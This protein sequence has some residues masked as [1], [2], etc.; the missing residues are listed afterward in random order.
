M[1]DRKKTLF[2]EIFFIVIFFF[3]CLWS[4]WIN[5][6]P[7]GYVIAQGDEP[8]RMNLVEDYKNY[9]YLWG[10][11]CGGGN[12]RESE[13]APLPQNGLY[14]L[15][16]KL[17]F[18]DTSRQNLKYFFFFFGSGLSAFF[19]CRLFLGSESK[20]HIQFLSALFY[21]FNSFT[22][23]A[24]VRMGVYYPYFDSY[25]FLPLTWAIFVRGLID[26]KGHYLA[27]FVLLVFI[28]G[29]GLGHA[30]FLVLFFSFMAATVIFLWGKKMIGRRQV[31]LA[32]VTLFFSVLSLSYYVLHYGVNLFF[33]EKGAVENM[34]A[35]KSL[36]QRILDMSPSLSNPLR[37]HIGGPGFPDIFPYKSLPK[38]PFLALAYYPVVLIVLAQIKVQSKKLRPWLF[39]AGVVY[40]ISLFGT[41]KT[42]VA[43]TLS[44]K[45]FSL[46]I[47][48]FFRSNE[49]FILLIPWAVLLYLIIFV[50]EILEKTSS[51]IKQYGLYLSITII[52]FLVSLPLFV[53]RLNDNFSIAY[54]WDYKYDVKVK[55]PEYYKE[56]AD[57]VNNDKDYYKALF[58]P[59]GGQTGTGWSLFPKWKYH[60]INPFFQYF[61]N[62][63]Y[64]PINGSC[65]FK[66]VVYLH[67]EPEK[68]EKLYIPLLQSKG[69]RY[70]VINNDSDEE[71]LKT[72][73]NF[74][75]KVAANFIFIKSF[76][77]LD[78]FRILPEKELP[79][80][81]ALSEEE[82]PSLVRVQG[83]QQ[84]FRGYYDWDEA[85]IRVRDVL[86]RRENAP[87]LSFTKISPVKYQVEIKG[88]KTP[89]W[90][91]FS[92][93]FSK[94]WKIYPNFGKKSLGDISFL[95]TEPL[96]SQ[97]IM[98]NDFANSW[99]INPEKEKTGENFS[100][101]IFFLPQV[102]FIFGL[103]ISII[104]VSVVV[105]YLL[106]FVGCNIY[107]KYGQT[108]H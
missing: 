58:M 77:N 43:G 20:P 92:D 93:T 60:G 48:S 16:A 90:L 18:S 95:F 13:L 10:Y 36:E 69:I 14:F 82:N 51:K 2:K 27:L 35:G 29:N 28:S 33:S 66:E 80:L 19:A 12:Y 71:Y 3:I 100:L 79:V 78:L 37:L 55:I 42:T 46:L 88:A 32:L 54:Q 70:L 49:K 89:F 4:W 85:Y 73:K 50:H 17:G 34:L 22:V 84:N 23:M 104:T 7:K 56:L 72:F 96:S 59:Y 40:I 65:E 1:K 38:W 76:G 9:F 94:N 99:Y 61:R 64:S 47:F 87:L 6:I 53:G 57:Y 41:A 108:A 81:Y 68:S 97:N 62:P 26:E 15:L 8:I 74:F 39:F 91:I 11:A 67:N 106:F 103:T 52:I 44:V 21:T 86:G 98:V 105:G 31:M 63:I 75:E 30:A 107:R 25:I 24:A 101:E 83:Y 102:I 5:R 45:I